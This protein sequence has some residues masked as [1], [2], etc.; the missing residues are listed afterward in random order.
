MLTIAMRV[1]AARAARKRGRQS[2]ACESTTLLD[3]DGEANLLSSAQEA[4]VVAGVGDEVGDEVGER[5]TGA[6]G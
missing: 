6:R 3:G 5:A 4:G 2:T 1:F